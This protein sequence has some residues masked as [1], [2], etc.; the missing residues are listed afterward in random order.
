[1]NLKS[2]IHQTNLRS[3]LECSASC[4]RTSGCSAFS[5]FE[6]SM[7]CELGNKRVLRLAQASTAAVNRTK[8]LATEGKF[9]GSEQLCVIERSSICSPS[10]L[11]RA[12]F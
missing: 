1:M 5:Y 4:A 11:A 2:F 3:E 9:A 12:K 10:L 6:D 8:V 7:T